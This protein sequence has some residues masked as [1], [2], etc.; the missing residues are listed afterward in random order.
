M[1]K[2][3]KYNQG[4]SIKVYTINSLNHTTRVTFQR[5]SKSDWRFN[6]RVRL[7]ELKQVNINGKSYVIR[8]VNDKK[9]EG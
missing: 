9:R 6:V 7:I 4:N 1:K 2:T 8:L 3:V 5:R